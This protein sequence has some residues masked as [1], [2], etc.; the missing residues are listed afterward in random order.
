M[1]RALASWRVI[2]VCCHDSLPCPM[3]RATYG[4]HPVHALKDLPFMLPGRVQ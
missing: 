2:I 4:A 3:L 1:E